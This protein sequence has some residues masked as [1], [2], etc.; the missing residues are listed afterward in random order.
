MKGRPDFYWRK[1]K[2]QGYPARSVFKLQEIQEKFHVVRPGGRILDLGASPGSWSLYLLDCLSA[3]RVT[4]V[5]LSAVDRRLA[6]R[7]N[8]RFLQGDFF[9]E[10]ITAQ[11]RAAGPFDAVLSD[12]APSTTGNR[13]SD[14]ARSLEICRRVLA[15]AV[16]VLSPGGNLAVKVF[17]G[18]EE[19]D[20]IE[21]M[22]GMFSAV[23]AFKPKASRQDSMEIYFV[24]TG[25]R[26][27]SQAGRAG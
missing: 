26:G 2:E 24:G 17:Q 16:E 3:G 4:G 11:I 27:P 25:F 6:A 5:D 1:S 14:T 15:I 19:R 20:L 7:R 13:T 12:A 22:R 23:R 10:D 21:E 18:G 9:A 8:Y